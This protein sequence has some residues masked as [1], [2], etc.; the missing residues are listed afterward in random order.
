MDIST[1]LA[2]SAG[3]FTAAWTIIQIGDRLWWKDETK[4]QPQS[5]MCG[6]QHAGI[7]SVL[8]EQTQQL[9]RVVDELAKNLNLEHERHVVIVTKLDAIKDAQ[10]SMTRQLERLVDQL[11]K[12]LDQNQ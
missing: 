10:Q 11:I 9:K 5:I 7:T 2:I 12:R 1:I 6:Q 8:N 3:V 4:P